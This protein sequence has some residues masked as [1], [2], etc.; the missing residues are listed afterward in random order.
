[1]TLQYTLYLSIIHA[2]CA[3]PCR[4][5]DCKGGRAAVI[6]N[7]RV[8]GLRGNNADLFPDTPECRQRGH[9]RLKGDCG[10]DL[11]QDLLCNNP[12]GGPVAC[13]SYFM[14]VDVACCLTH[15]V[16]LLYEL[17][18]LLQDFIQNPADTRHEA[19]SAGTSHFLLPSGLSGEQNTDAFGV[20]HAACAHTRART[21]WLCGTVAAPVFDVEVL[22]QMKV[23]E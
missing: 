10:N 17:H 13:F 9:W 6:I 16:L 23:F 2:V 21:R 3:E 14:S 7:E 1:M 5:R 4:H 12:D 18:Q 22:A 11:F 8:A 20:A 19:G 15:T